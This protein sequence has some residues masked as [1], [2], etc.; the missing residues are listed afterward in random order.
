M[1]AVFW[2]YNVIIIV[3]VG[4]L[5]IKTGVRYVHFLQDGLK[6]EGLAWGTPW[7]PYR[8]ILTWPIVRIRLR[9]GMFRDD[10]EH[11]KNNRNEDSDDD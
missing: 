3:L 8:I 9:W 10:C 5:Y 2:V 11:Y 4:W 1:N 7:T 6:A